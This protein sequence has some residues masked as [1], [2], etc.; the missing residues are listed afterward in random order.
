LRRPEIA[1]GHPLAK[2][3]TIVRKAGVLAFRF[4][5]GKLEVLLITVT[6]SGRWTLPKGNIGPGET[7]QAAAAREARE[8]AGVEGTFESEEPIGIYKYAKR[9]RNGD[10]QPAVVEV[11]PMRVLKQFSSWPEMHRR[12]LAWLSITK[13]TKTVDQPGIARLLNRLAELEPMLTGSV[14]GAGIPAM[15]IDDGIRSL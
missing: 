6:D 5:S 2:I 14:Q 11:F 9:L 10:S 7:S 8:E 3:E 1:A 12:K 13:A 4:R 15:S